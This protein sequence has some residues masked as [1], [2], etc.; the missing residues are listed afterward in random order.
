MLLRLAISDE[1][2]QFWDKKWQMLM[3][4][5]MQTPLSELSIFPTLL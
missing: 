4:S 1:M 3:C 5:N 2:V